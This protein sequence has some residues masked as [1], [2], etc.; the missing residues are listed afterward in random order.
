MQH[1]ALKYGIAWFT[2]VSVACSAT[3]DLRGA[4][5]NLMVA[6]LARASLWLETAKP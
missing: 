3:G 2:A 6:L 4:W 5:F 1:R